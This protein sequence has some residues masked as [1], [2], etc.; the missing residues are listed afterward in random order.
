MSCVREAH[1][2]YFCPNVLRI[3][4]T[5]FACFKHVTRVFFS[6]DGSAAEWHQTNQLVAGVSEAGAG[7]RRRD[8]RSLRKQ[9]SA[10][11]RASAAARHR[12]GK[13]LSGVEEQWHGAAVQAN[14]D[15]WGC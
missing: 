10:V 9:L 2:F 3:L 13:G 8:G 6:N 4:S 12:L 1:D 11:G 14:A 15:Q 5:F 7:Q